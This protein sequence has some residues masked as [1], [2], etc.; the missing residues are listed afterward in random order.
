MRQAICLLGLLVAVTGC[1]VST[2]PAPRDGGGDT[3]GSVQGVCTPGSPGFYCDGA[4][5]VDC[6]ADGSERMRTD[7]AASGQTCV[8][9]VGC[10]VCRA[11]T[12]RCQGDNVEQ[13]RFDGSGWEHI[14]TCDSAAGQMCSASLGICRDACSDA[15]ASNSYIG[16][17][18]WPVVTSNSQVASEFTPAIVVANPQQSAAS[19]TVTGPD[20]FNHTRS[21]APGSVETIELRW[22]DALKNSLGSE[23]SALVRQGSYRLVSTLP[24]TVYQFNPLEYRIDR[25]CIDELGR[26][27]SSSILC[28]NVCFSHSNDASLLLPTHV[29]T[30]NYIVMARPTLQL[31][32]SGTLLTSPGFFT[33]VGVSETPVTVNIQ[34]NA[35]TLAGDGVSAQRQ[36]TS[37]SY[38]LNQGDVLQVLSDSPSSCTRGR[39]ESGS[40]F[41]IVGDEYDL[42]GTEIRA[43]GPVQVIGGHNCDFVPYDR[44]AC[45]HSEEAIFPLETWGTETIVSLTQ[46]PMGRDEPNVIRIVSGVDGNLISFEPAT[47]GGGSVILNRG[48]LLEFEAHQNFRATGTGPF[49]LGQ[50]IVGQSYHDSTPHDAQG[51]PS[52][53]LGIPS[54]QF[55]TEYTFL[56]PSTYPTN[57]VNVTAPAG[58]TINL[59][60]TAVGGFQPVGGTGF[61]VAR[62]PIPAGQHK[63][64]STQPFG[65]VVYGYG[66]Y[67]SYM[68]PGGLDFEVI[69]IF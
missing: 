11:N 33:V 18:Y 44:Y 49:L 9:G 54:E 39:S 19:V 38:T 60:G 51:D 62:V 56:A 7:C 53:S 29:L 63:I 1:E 8:S 36:G 23:R 3:D 48:Q 15:A 43:S 68:Y 52:F 14:A 37:A 25:D 12:F 20:G 16:C 30:G 69:N 35:H 57:F 21:I 27:D 45:D 64:E 34:F 13:C 41:C 17:E 32:R 58:A 65:I 4:Y 47:V 28:D 31:Q 67:T 50:F 22:V 66:S 2:S 5:A 55:R 61:Q 42:T 59:N 10:A 26:C 24:V 46:A 40:T 6:L